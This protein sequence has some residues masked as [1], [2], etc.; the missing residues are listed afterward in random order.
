MN[1]QKEMQVQQEQAL[2]EVT[3]KLEDAESLVEEIVESAYG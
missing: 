2:Q 1:K 3:V